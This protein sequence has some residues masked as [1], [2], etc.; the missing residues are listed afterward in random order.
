MLSSDR[1][2]TRGD[3][4]EAKVRVHHVLLLALE[5]LD[6]PHDARLLRHVFNLA[7]RRLRNGATASAGRC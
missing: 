1:E 3:G 5:L 7:N 2:R 6:L 4:G